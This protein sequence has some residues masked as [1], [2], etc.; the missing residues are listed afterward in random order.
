MAC[1]GLKSV[2]IE[3][4]G[5]LGEISAQYLHKGSQIFLEGRLKTDI[6]EAKNSETK[7][8]T[9]VVASALQM[10]DKKPED[11]PETIVEEETA[12]TES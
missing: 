5:R 6:Y 12:E 3:A 10:L 1:G 7:Y 9:K 4:W 11:E 2:N 8:F